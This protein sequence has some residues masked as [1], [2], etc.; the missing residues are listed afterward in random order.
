MKTTYKN[1]YSRSTA[2]IEKTAC[3][4][5]DGAPVQD[6]YRTIF[7]DADGFVYHISCFETFEDARRD[8]QK[9]GYN[10]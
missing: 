10:A 2:I 4:P 1:K 6:C 3:R 7:T 8:L 9:C 5:Y